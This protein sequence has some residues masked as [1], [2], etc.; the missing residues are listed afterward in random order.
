MQHSFLYYLTTVLTSC[1]QL[2][3]RECC[4][5]LGRSQALY[6]QWV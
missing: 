3:G 4:C 6:M 1:K 5:D 2:G